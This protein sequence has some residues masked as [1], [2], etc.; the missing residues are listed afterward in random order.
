VDDYIER[1]AP[2]ARSILNHLRK[3]VHTAC[4]EVEETVRWSSPTFLY[5]GMMCG[6]ASFKSHCTFGFWKGSLVLGD[7]GRSADAMGNFGRIERISDLPSAKQLSGYVKKAMELNVEGVKVVRRTSPR[8][9]LPV[10]PDLAAALGKNKKARAAFDAFPPSHQR[11]YV[12]WVTEAKRDD[13]RRRRLE[14]AI[15]LIAE[16]KPRHWKYQKT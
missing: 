5:H 1:S 15:E 11:E 6:M 16:G 14:T 9:P 8:K 4:P 7:N 12:E 3:V 2:F 13:T 10:P